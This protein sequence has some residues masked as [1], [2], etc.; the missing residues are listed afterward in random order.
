MLSLYAMYGE[1]V[2]ALVRAITGRMF[3]EDQIKHLTSATVG[4]YFSEFF[5]TPKDELAAHERVEK[6]GEHMAAA[7][8]IIREMQQD[9]L[10]Q[11]KKLSHLREEIDQKKQL[12]ERYQVLAESSGKVF[13]AF[14]EEMEDALRTELMQQAERGRRL[15]QVV[16]LVVWLITLLVGAGV[17]AY[18][19]DIVAWVK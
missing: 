3:T 8:T 11:E 9:L 17:G 5:P 7:S 13:Q 19:R 16:S 4:K 15:R 12:A 10:E 2:A 1:L 18:F 14:R 6:A